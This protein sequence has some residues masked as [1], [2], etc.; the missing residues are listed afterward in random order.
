MGRDSRGGHIPYKMR[1][2]QTLPSKSVSA[3]TVLML[4]NLQCKATT[5]VMAEPISVQ[6]KPPQLATAQRLDAMKAMR[7]GRERTCQRGLPR[8]GL[9]SPCMGRSSAA[10]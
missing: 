1:S 4:P 8:S 9:P 6:T 5:G 2:T 10:S 7:T 3:F